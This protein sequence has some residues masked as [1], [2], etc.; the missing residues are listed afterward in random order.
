MM[1]CTKMYVEST[2]TLMGQG[3]EK[4]LLILP[5]ELFENIRGHNILSRIIN[6]KETKM[7]FI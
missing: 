6:T 3:R 1:L 7:S 4:R 5:K 2:E